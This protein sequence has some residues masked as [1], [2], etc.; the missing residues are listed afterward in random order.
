LTSAAPTPKR[1]VGR[2]ERKREETRASLT[3]SAL[4]L[5][6]EHGFDAVTVTEIT[7][8]SD[9]D[10]STFFRHFRSK[11]SVL[12]TDI[13]GYVDH[14]RPLIDQRP[15]DEPIIETLRETTR[16]WSSSETFD[17][18]LENLRAKLTES[19]SE[20]RAHVVIRREQVALDL[21]DLL[22]ARFGVDP[23]QDAR[24]YLAATVWL[25][26]FD[27]YR[28]HLVSAHDQ[29]MDAAGAVDEIVT[30][31]ESAGRFF[32]LTPEQST[33]GPTPARRG[34]RSDGAACRDGARP[35]S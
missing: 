26:A 13:E 29:V 28:R 6:G 34:V 19:S 23:S 11:E 27:W 20:L 7:D 14:V 15:V 17:L 22:G 16:A 9:V 32:E 30:I 21:A 33:G 25:A 1:A 8:R 24:P 35:Q 2:R 4:E 3:R 12:F 10:P 5:F 18:E 31:V